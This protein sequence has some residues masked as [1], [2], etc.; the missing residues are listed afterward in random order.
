MDD[1]CPQTGGGS[2]QP[3]DEVIKCAVRCVGSE[4]FH[5]CTCLSHL[6]VVARDL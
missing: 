1:E 6:K 4:N 2:Q 3:A 5:F